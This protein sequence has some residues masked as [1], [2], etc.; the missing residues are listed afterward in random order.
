MDRRFSSLAGCYALFAA[1]A[2]SFL[3]YAHLALQA[4]APDWLNEPVLPHDF[5]AAQI[6]AS[7]RGAAAALREGMHTTW[8]FFAVFAA[9]WLACLLWMQIERRRRQLTFSR[10][11]AIWAGWISLLVL[12]LAVL[13]GLGTNGIL[14][15]RTPAIVNVSDVIALG[16]MLALPVIAWSR[17]RGQE[18]DFPEDSGETASLRRSSGFLGLSD[19]ESNARLAESLSRLEVRPELR[20]V[21]LLPAV[22]IFNPER[23]AE[24]TKMAA[25]RLIESAELPAPPPSGPQ[26]SNPQLSSPAPSSPDSSPSAIVPIAAAA[27]EPAAKGID[28]FRNHLAAMNGSWQ[29]IENIRAE[30]DDWFEQRRRQAIAHLDT[31]PGMRSP[32]LASELFQDFPNEKLVAVDAQWAG[33]RTA[34]L[35]ISRWFGDLPAP[36]SRP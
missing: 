33:I 3:V 35:E 29:R 16:F 12:S 1:L 17:L 20:P 21:D 13:Y 14:A 4:R 23:S 8:L 27:D 28:A 2:A 22:Q 36:D 24:H 25:N 5:H 9:V 31:H 15:R 32:A 30:I 26:P 6:F 10:Q 11:E 18:G 19:E 34:A 7:I